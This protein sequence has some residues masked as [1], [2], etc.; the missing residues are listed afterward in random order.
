M[1]KRPG[2]PEDFDLPPLADSP[3]TLPHY[4]EAR[5]EVEAP[6]QRKEPVKLVPQPQAT[7][8]TAP[9]TVVAADAEER[10]APPPQQQKVVKLS[11]APAAAEAQAPQQPGA[12]KRRASKASKKRPPRMEVGCDELG[13]KRIR[14]IVGDLRTKTPQHDVTASE[15]LQAAAHLIH[16]A[17]QYADYSSLSPRGLWGTDTAK[18]FIHDLGETYLRA[19]GE[20]WFEMNYQAIRQR[21][22]AD[23]QKESAG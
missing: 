11:A 18:E 15:F 10:P 3:V 21:I 6:P 16:R 7:P 14:D 17:R 5:P 4:L 23:I 13:R 22:E 2:L 19:V 12:R 9:P 20:L 8:K 1:P